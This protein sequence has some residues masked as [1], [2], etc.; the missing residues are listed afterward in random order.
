MN[1]THQNKDSHFSK[2]FLKILSL[3]G[4]I[5][6][7]DGPQVIYRQTTSKLPSRA[8]QSFTFEESHF[9]IISRCVADLYYTASCHSKL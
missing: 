6:F 7:P 2:Y 4:D 3:S 5:T 8:A 1:Y 9:R